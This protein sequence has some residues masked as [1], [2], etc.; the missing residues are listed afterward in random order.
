MLIVGTQVRNNMKT[1]KGRR[2][3]TQKILSCVT[4]TKEAHLIEQTD[5]PR[6]GTV[7]PEQEDTSSAPAKDGLK[8]P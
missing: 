1:R 6:P 2:R 7:N 5:Q 4:L 3:N 8:P